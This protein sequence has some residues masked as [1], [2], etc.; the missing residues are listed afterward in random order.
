[1]LEAARYQIDTLQPEPDGPK[2]TAPDV[3]IGQLK[4]R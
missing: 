4:R 1:V 3:A 2:I